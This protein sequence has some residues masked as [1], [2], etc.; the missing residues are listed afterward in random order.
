MHVEISRLLTAVR[1]ARVAQVVLQQKEIQTKEQIHVEISRC[2]TNTC[3]NI[4]MFDKYK[5]ERS[6][7]LAAVRTECVAQVVLKQGAGLTTKVTHG[8]KQAPTIQIQ[9]QIQ[10]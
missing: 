3:R 8:M 6:S 5:Y 7:S 4:E 10:M 2:L 1:T 9:I